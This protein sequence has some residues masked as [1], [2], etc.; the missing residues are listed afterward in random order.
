MFIME[1]EI[2]FDKFNTKRVLEDKVAG[3]SVKA[4]V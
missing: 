2:S 4:G 1:I 3:F